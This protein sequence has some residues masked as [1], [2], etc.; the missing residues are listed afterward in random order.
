MREPPRA[1]HWHQYSEPYPPAIA[2]PLKLKDRTPGAQ[3]RPDTNESDA[4][5]IV[6]PGGVASTNVKP[7]APGVTMHV[8]SAASPV[9]V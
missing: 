1:S 3:S 6:A 7:S 5:R 2:A 8:C 4:A 9:S